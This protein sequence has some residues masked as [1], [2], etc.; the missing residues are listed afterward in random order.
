M[1]YKRCYRDFCRKYLRQSFAILGL[2][3][4]AA[5]AQAQQ[6]VPRTVFVHLFEWR[7]DDIARECETFLGPKGFAAVQVSPPNEHRVAPA[8]PWWERYQPVSYQI[9]SRS[10]NRQ[11]FEDMVKRCKAA[12]VKIYADAVINHMTGPG[13]RNDPKFGTGSGG[14]HYGY[15][16]Y[17]PYQSQEA[18][19]SPHCNIGNDYNDRWKVQNCDLVG[20]AD[21]NTGSEQVQ[22]TIA[23][24]LNDLLSLGVAGFRIDAAKHINTN[25]IHSILAKVQDKPEIYQEVIEAAGQPIQAP[26]YFQ[27]GLVIEFNYGSKIAEFFH[28]SG[29]LRLAQLRTFGPTW[30]ELMPSEKAVVFVDNHDTQRGRTGGGDVITYKDGRLYNLANVFM[31]A[32]PYGYPQIMSSFAFSDPDAGPPSD[33]NGNTNQIYQGNQPNCFKEWNCEHRWREITNMVAFRNNTLAAWSVDNWWDNGNNQIAFGR[34]NLGFV[35]INKENSTLDHTYQTGLRAGSYC[36]AWDGELSNNACTGSVITVNADGTAHFQ[37]PPWT[38][39]AIH[40]GAIIPPDGDKGQRTVVLI[41]AETIPGQDM[42]IRG[43]IDHDYANSKLNRNC[44]TSNY[45]CAIPIQHLNLKNPT[46]NPW[47]QGDNYLDWY[48]RESNQNGSSHGMLAEGTPLDWTTNKWPDAWVPKHTVAADGFGE[49][50]L[51]QYGLHYWML[52][53][54]MDCSRTADGWFEFKSYISNGPGWEGDINQAGTPYASRNHFG[55]CGY[56]NVYQRGKNEVVKMLPL[57]Q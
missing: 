3:L 57:Q 34:G 2:L 45:N 55:K 30:K 17:P 39:A 23:A 10:G 54:K 49:E 52:D 46:T 14:S 48:G 22:N 41:Q 35:V 37:V 4:L 27:N 42:F 19:H 9:V 24:Y 50:P 44:S 12:G 40:V 36:N 56:V 15:Y 43:G 18:F 32:W 7:W 16:S 25:D 29:G 38:A 31:L 8:Y 28:G 11:Q 21:L 5:T 13:G 20:L 51:N 33:A 26:E 53:V 6:Q 1:K 47:K